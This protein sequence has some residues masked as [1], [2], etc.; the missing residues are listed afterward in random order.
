MK[1]SRES[2]LAFI[3]GILFVASP[4]LGCEETAPEQEAR[5]GMCYFWQPGEYMYVFCTGPT[6]DAH[7]CTYEKIQSEAEGKDYRSSG[8]LG[9][10]EDMATCTRDRQAV[11]D[12]YEESG[13]PEP[14]PLSNEMSGGSTNGGGST[15]GG[16][17]G[18]SNTSAQLNAKCMKEQKDV[19]DN[20]TLECNPVCV[21]VDG[22]NCGISSYCSGI[23]PKCAALKA[24]GCSCSWCP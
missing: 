23:A 24:I 1:K 20:C 17:V 22:C 19:Y 14:G 9:R 21:Y 6:S 5:V 16:G 10:Y 3:L 7:I 15:S 11:L 4:L 2:R 13:N 18:C 8:T 12:A